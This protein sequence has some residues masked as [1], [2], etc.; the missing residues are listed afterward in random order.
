MLEKE[1]G[2]RESEVDE[3]SRQSERADTQETRESQDRP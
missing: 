2:G 3:W 1:K